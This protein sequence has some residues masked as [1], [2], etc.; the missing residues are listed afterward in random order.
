MTTWAFLGAG[1]FQPWHAEVDALLLDDRAGQ[2]LVLATASAPEGEAVYNGWRRKG[3]AHFSEAG[4]PVLAP[5]LRRRE[6]AFHADFVSLLDD[7]A[8]VFFSG[9][10]PAYVASVLIGSPFWAT[11]WERLTDGRTAYAGCSAGVACLSD[12]T[13]DS[14]ATDPSSVWA[15]GLGVFPSTLFAPHWDTIDQ[16]RPGAQ[17]FIAGA[18]PAAGVVVGLDEDTALVGDGEHWRVLGLGGVHVHHADDAPNVW[19]HHLA[20]AAVDLLLPH[21]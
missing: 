2:V 17:D 7:A 5:D 14:A 9:G 21:E 8:L 19:S 1:E 11:L 18:V 3:E 16:W 13:F 12:P 20:G 4:V 6:D 15:P 10:N